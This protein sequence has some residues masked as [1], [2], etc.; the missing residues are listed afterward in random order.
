VIR[1]VSVELASNV[2]EIVIVK[3]E[4]RIIFKDTTLVTRMAGYL[5]RLNK[6]AVEVRLH[7]S[8]F[9]KDTDSN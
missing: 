3:A 4:H 9:L 7:L 1:F 2:S 6:E 5:G 8:N